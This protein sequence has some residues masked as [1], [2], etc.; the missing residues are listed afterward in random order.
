MKSAA[1]WA[2][3]LCCESPLA[4]SF[5]LHLTAFYSLELVGKILM[6]VWPRRH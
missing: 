2:K 1:A 6:C 4:T 5:S 3:E